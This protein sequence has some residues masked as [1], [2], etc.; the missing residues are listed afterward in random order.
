MYFI[1]SGLSSACYISLWRVTG[2]LAE[3]P[4]NLSML[5]SPTEVFGAFLCWPAKSDLDSG[6][7]MQGNIASWARATPSLS[8]TQ[9][10]S[11]Q[12]V[13]DFSMFFWDYI[14]VSGC[15]TYRGQ[16]GKMKMRACPHQRE[17]V[18]TLFQ[19]TSVK[20]T[21]IFFS[22]LYY[23]VIRFSC[24]GNY[25]FFAKWSLCL[26]LLAL[27]EC[28]AGNEKEIIAVLTVPF[29]AGEQCLRSHTEM[30]DE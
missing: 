30:G 15:L 8:G 13:W 12:N 14:W 20:T 27:Q 24:V 18:S 26:E 22:F 16:E 28:Q 25:N 29:N 1:T 6:S 10:G 9:L 17:F 23:K 2:R 3:L 4:R 21:L 5:G 7:T 11:W 19:R